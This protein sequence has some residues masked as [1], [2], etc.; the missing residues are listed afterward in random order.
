[1]YILLFTCFTFNNILNKL[2]NI[3]LLFVNYCHSSF[4]SISIF[5]VFPFIFHV[6]VYVYFTVEY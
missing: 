3:L 5:Q 2:E 1:M 4:S 6:N